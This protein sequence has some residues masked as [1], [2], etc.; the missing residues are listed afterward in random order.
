MLKSRFKLSAYSIRNFH[1]KEFIGKQDTFYFQK[2]NLPSSEKTPVSLVLGWAGS[3]D[4]HVIKYSNIYNQLG[5]HVIRFAPSFTWT[6]LK[7][8]SHRDYADELVYKIKNEYSLKDNPLIVHTFSNAGAFLFSHMYEKASEDE[9]YSFLK[10]NVKAHIFDSGPGFE[11]NSE[12]YSEFINTVYKLSNSALKYKPI[13]FTISTALM[14]FMFFRHMLFIKGRNY[15]NKRIEILKESNSKVPILIFYSTIDRLV[16]Y[17]AVEEFIEKK[18]EKGVDVKVI[19]FEDTEH[20]MHFIKHKELYLNE[21][22]E[23]LIRNNL[24][25]PKTDM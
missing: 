4:N 20:C 11:L 21:L 7:T 25:I 3:K 12:N 18:K 24:P 8:S 5:Y 10:Q 14:L 9:K 19:R 17:G 1:K 22:K 15:F 2:S 16:W 13:G 23:H 6:F